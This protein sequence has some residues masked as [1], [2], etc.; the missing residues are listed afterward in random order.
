MYKLGV[1]CLLK[2]VKSK[3]HRIDND[4]HDE[5]DNWGNGHPTS[6]TTVGNSGFMERR[7]NRSL[8]DDV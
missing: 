1:D 4:Q 3:S 8:F 7:P 6:S 2:R 5:N